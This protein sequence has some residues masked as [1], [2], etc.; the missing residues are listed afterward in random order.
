MQARSRSLLASLTPKD[1]GAPRAARNARLSIPTLLPTRSKMLSL[2]SISLLL[3]AMPPAAPAQGQVFTKLNSDLANMATG[4]VEDFELSADGS[5]VVYTSYETSDEDDLE[6]YSIPFDLSGPRV[7]LTSSFVNE[8]DL[9][10]VEILP[11]SDTVLF[12]SDESGQYEIYRV[13]IDG[14]SAPTSLT[15]GLGVGLFD[16]HPDGQ[17]L[18]YS[19][20]QTL[21]VIPIDGSAAPMA[22]GDP[23]V[24]SSSLPTFYTPDNLRV[25]YSLNNG[26][27]PAVYSS[28]LDTPNSWTDHTSNWVTGTT[29]WGPHGMSGDGQHVLF[30]MR[31]P[32]SDNELFTSPMDGSLPPA[33]VNP[34]LDNPSEEV[35]SFKASPVGNR[36]VYRSNH[37]NFTKYQL[38]SRPADLSA[39]EKKLSGAM[40]SDADVQGFGV[41]PDGQS[42]VFEADTITN[43]VLELFVTGIAGGGI[44]QL[45]PPYATGGDTNSFAFFEDSQWLLFEADAIVDGRDEL[46]AVPL[47]GSSSAVHLN[48]SGPSAGFP[49][50]D[51]IAGPNGSVLFRA[52]SPDGIALYSV[53]RDGSSA[54]VRINGPN[55]NNGGPWFGY[56]LS[57]DGGEILY[58]SDE[59]F[60]NHFQ[61]FGKSFGSAE[62]RYDLSELP[63]F[64]AGDVDSFEISADSQW[65]VYRADQDVDG[66]FELYSVPI[67]GGVPVAI[68]DV[69]VGNSFLGAWTITDDS[70]WVVFEGNRDNPG[71]R[72]LYRTPIDGSGL[73]VR[74]NQ[75]LP[76]NTNNDTYEW[77]LV[78]SS[79]VYTAKDF[80]AFGANL[81]VRPLD[82]SVPEIRLNTEQVVN[83]AVQDFL[84]SPNGTHVVYRGD[85]VING[86]D[87]LFG[88]PIDGSANSVQLNTNSGENADVDE[89]VISP[90]GLHVA[91][92]IDQVNDG[93]YSVYHAPIDGSSASNLVSHAFATTS[94]DAYDPKFSLDST[95]ISYLAYEDFNIDRNLHSADLSGAGH[96]LLTPVMAP[97]GDA[98]SN[99]PISGNRILYRADQI[100]DTHVDLFVID[101]QGASGALDLDPGLPIFADVH[102]AMVHP[103][104]EQVLYL[105]DPLIEG[106]RELFST[107]L[108][109]SSAPYRI[110]GLM[111]IAGD[112]NLPHDFL[113]GRP[114]YRADQQINGKFEVYWRMIRN[115][116]DT[117]QLNASL[118]SNR[119]VLDSAISPDQAFCVY[120]ADQDLDGVNELYSR[121]TV[122]TLV[123]KP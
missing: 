117:P 37:Q 23:S 115:S 8:V 75:V 14:S 20:S 19:F 41:S 27:N 120:L 76:S 100:I 1:R 98:L 52:S 116:A 121:R 77:T 54:P 86:R 62:P 67:G 64:V 101:D 73:P 82:L 57:A 28:P 102:D 61:I 16:V 105:A 46:Y 107:R 39:P 3:L 6:L 72:Y 119:D 55:T 78:G 48:S 103:D 2:P 49:V 95:R 22:I 92:T 30:K 5:W 84:V 51:Y 15:P 32:G 99:T 10:D 40:P 74:I 91:F 88:V 85:T 36:V 118:D 68:A 108:D 44:T 106:D 50:F 4:S 13:P 31:L 43:G 18:I 96:V 69:Q 70:Q 109:G 9:R 113:L 24:F 110:S 123:Q 60:D 71:N 83:G 25:V 63:T 17:R 58:R 104:G 33:L 87:S 114:V 81:F 11:T 35:E 34:P 29:L 26:T 93:S 45:N 59:N 89:Y 65:V 97:G 80:V 38:Y 111:T 112:A 12:R 47:D 53:P 94:G 122:A 21:W 42:V 7:Q 56:Q 66:F 79:I 90:D